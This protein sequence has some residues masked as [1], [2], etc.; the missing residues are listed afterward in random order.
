ME[1]R[2]LLAVFLSFLVLVV[3]QRFVAPPPVPVQSFVD[4]SAEPGAVAPG[5][6]AAT[7]TSSS[8]AVGTAPPVPASPSAPVQAAA[9]TAFTPTV[10]DSAD[11]D[12]VVESDL[13]RAVFSNRG[14]ELISWQLKEYGDDSGG[15]VELIPPDVSPDQAWP[16]SLVVPGNPDL[17]ARLDQ[18]L[19]RPSL[20]RLRLTG[21]SGTLAFEYEDSSGLRARKS[22]SFQSS[23]EQPYVVGFSASVSTS[24]GPVPLT[25]R[26]G[27][28]LGGVRENTSRLVFQQLPGAVL[29]GRVFEDG[30]LEDADVYRAAPDDLADRGIYDGQFTFAGVDN[31][32]FAAVAL[33][34]IEQAVV[35]FQPV[36]TLRREHDL[37]AFDLTVDPGMAEIPMFIGPKDFDILGAVHP[38]LVRVIDFGWL[39]VLVVPLHRT[40]KW[41]Y[42]FLGNY[43][44]SIILLT[45]MINIVIFPLRHK[46]VVSMRKMQELQ[47][48]MKAIQARYADLKAT[49]PGKQKM[50]GEVMELYRKHGANPASGCLPML[51]TMPILFAFY[52]LLSMAIEMRG[53]PFIFWITDLSVH[54]P[55]Y[56]T[57]VIMGASMVVQQRLQPSAADPTQQKIMMLMPVMFTF[58]FLWAPGGLVVYW[59]TSNVF[60]IGQTIITNRLSG[61][62]RTRQVRPPAERK[63][64]TAAPTKTIDVD[65]VEPTNS[66]AERPAGREGGK[67]GRQGRGGRRTR[68]KGTR[69]EA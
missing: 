41:I 47:P 49:D 64:K 39:S 44:W 63:V 5:P 68:G 20:D 46:S 31:H 33:P 67:R 10:F 25:I 51:L 52:R 60:G 11:R 48:E 54:D 55:F 65:P 26:W 16:F 28:A 22:F 1:R 57:P 4:G 66:D 13:V 9:G 62:T 37:V 38:D 29:Y 7:A 69:G 24:T 53:A 6:G 61:P 32:Y 59:L 27:P 23:P 40:L 19:F 18:A 21:E 15:Q 12:I 50:N 14:A 56:V 45:V 35:A 30:L 42:G 36:S 34:G 58:M 43:G 3:Y 8:A 2:V 17:T